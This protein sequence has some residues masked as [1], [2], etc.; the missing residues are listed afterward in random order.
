M[1][2]INYSS[3]SA[4]ALTSQSNSS[5]GNY[6][7]RVISATAQ[8][9]FLP[10]DQKYHLRPDK[11]A[12]DLYGKSGLYWVFMS[13]NLDIIRDPIWDFKAGTEIFMPDADQLK[14]TLGL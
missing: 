2:K 3:D 8:D 6:V 9:Q 10:I 14:K 11:L 13:R 5:I 1:T 12:Y 4:Y 7:H